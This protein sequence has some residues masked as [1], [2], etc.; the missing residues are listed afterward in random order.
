MSEL[1]RLLDEGANADEARLLRAAADDGWSPEAKERV[2][3]AL[4]GAGAMT[5][6][7]ASAATGAAVGHAVGRAGLGWLARFLVSAATV[8][9]GASLVLRPVEEL[10]SSPSAPSGATSGIASGEPQAQPS[11]ESAAT[12]KAPSDSPTPPAS[13]AVQAPKH[14]PQVSDAHPASSA[15]LS[16][17]LAIIDTAREE[18]RSNRS[19]EA[20]STLD[21]YAKSYPRGAFG[22]EAMLVRIEALLAL[23]QRPEAVRLAH[24]FLERAPSSPYARR[25]R[26]LIGEP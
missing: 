13:V 8:V 22:P 21:R 11:E 4:V 2:A 17:Q 23:G 6:A 16:D 5:T 15:S 18:V 25:V 7:G 1:R 10:A 24:Q 19:G 12:P 26:S 3:S 14:D 20:L 9:G